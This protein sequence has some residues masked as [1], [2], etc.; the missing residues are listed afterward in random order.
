MSDP[1]PP[2]IETNRP[3]LKQTHEGEHH[4]DYGGQE[5]PLLHATKVFAL[6]AAVNSCNLGFDIGVSTSVGQLIQ[7]DFELSDIEREIF[8][9][10]LNFFAMFG[11]FFSNWF[12]D[13]YGR[14]QTF[15]VAAIG[16]IFGI[17]VEALAPNFSILLFGRIFVG[18]GVGIG[19]A[20]DPVYISEISPAKHRGFLVT[21]SEIA[22][23]IGIVLGF[24]MGIFFAGM[25]AGAQWRIMLAV[26]MIMPSIMIFL[27]IN[28]MPESP[29]Y[30]VSTGKEAEAKVVLEQVYPVDYPVNEIID[31]IKEALE[32]ERI[33]EHS[34][35]WSVILSPTPAFRRMLMV[36]VGTAIA[37]QAVGI[38]ALQYYLVDVLDSSGLHSERKQSFLMVCLGGVKLGVIFVSGHLFDSRGRRPLFFASLLGA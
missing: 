6:C 31:D 13:T 34:L 4:G 24:S 23:N 19:M 3:Q 9:G 17:I 35:G 8:V 18:L 16:F 7:E 26:G 38:D 20:V 10:S 36:G 11:A 30:L 27:V 21:W 29:R 15:L 22:I 25:S 12:S 28:I 2:N 14:R 5:I 1:L 32:R 33:A 37:Q